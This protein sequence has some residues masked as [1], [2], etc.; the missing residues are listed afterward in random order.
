MVQN[1]LNLQSPTKEKKRKIH[2]QNLPEQDYVTS[3][4]RLS[5]IFLESSYGGL[6]RIA[7]MVKTNDNE[8]KNPDSFSTKN[9]SLFGAIKVPIDN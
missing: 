6:Y 1:S 9:F 5:N 7:S 2:A 3:E 8:V 4:F